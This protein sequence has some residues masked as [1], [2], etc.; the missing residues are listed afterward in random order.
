MP[1]CQK[2]QITTNLDHIFA[3][4]YTLV[5]CNVSIK[6][7][8]FRFREIRRQGIDGQTDGQ[9]DWRGTI[10]NAAPRRAA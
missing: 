8:A 7:V 9:T 6:L 5:Q 2:L 10:L 3:A 1:G 4:I